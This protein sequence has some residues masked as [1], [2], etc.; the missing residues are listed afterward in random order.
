[1][2]DAAGPT[3]PGDEARPRTVTGLVS[4][5]K[6]IINILHACLAK[7]L[8]VYYSICGGPCSY[9]CGSILGIDLQ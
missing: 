7:G 1:M 8:E 6:R 4:K 5:Y 2:E 9:L 3:L